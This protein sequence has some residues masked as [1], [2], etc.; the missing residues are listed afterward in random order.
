VDALGAAL[1][2]K[3][4][5]K[6]GVRR[7]VA[8]LSVNSGRHAAT[9][10]GQTQIHPTHINTN[11]DAS[12]GSKRCVSARAHRRRGQEVHVE[13]GKRSR[14]GF[15]RSGGNHPPAIDRA[16]TSV[17]SHSPCS[18]APLSCRGLPAA[19]HSSMMGLT[20]VML[21]KAG[22]HAAWNG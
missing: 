17:G 22:G 7:A 3:M 20:F 13:V 15:V 1:V 16:D 5:E 4:R 6:F 18:T 11:E 14:G 12:G 8:I 19:V 21:C 2:N 10:S 9:F